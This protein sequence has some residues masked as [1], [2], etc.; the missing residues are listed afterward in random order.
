MV[1]LEQEPGDRLRESYRW[2]EFPLNLFPKTQPHLMQLNSGGNK[3]ISCAL[4]TNWIELLKYKHHNLPAVN[5]RRDEVEERRGSGS[6]ERG[7][8]D[9]IIEIGA[10][11]LIKCDNIS[12]CCG[13]SNRTYEEFLCH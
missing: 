10:L 7:I 4:I 6:G 11:L 13:K 12:I 1:N 5:V 8:N 9:I 3:D 2:K